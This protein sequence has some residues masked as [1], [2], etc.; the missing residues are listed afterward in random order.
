MKH[1]GFNSN[2]PAKSL[3]LAKKA[4][5]REAKELGVKVGNDALVK[6]AEKEVRRK[7]AGQAA[8]GAGATAAG[9][10]ELKDTGFLGGVTRAAQDR[11][12]RAALLE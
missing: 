2:D 3:R 12:R 8:G 4:I 9:E 5:D 1:N 10:P 7:V 11:E 6:N